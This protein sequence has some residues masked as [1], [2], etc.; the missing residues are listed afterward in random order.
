MVRRNGGNRHDN[1]RNKN[2]FL[3]D[4]VVDQKQ[5]DMLV[6]FWQFVEQVEQ[7]GLF[8][9]LVMF[10]WKSEGD[11]KILLINPKPQG[12]A[13]NLAPLLGWSNMQAKGRLNIFS[14]LATFK[15]KQKTGN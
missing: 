6:Y 11:Q 10:A 4:H 5:G 8:L 1:D 14:A 2:A 9:L 15:C 13:Q 7:H 3:L 12:K